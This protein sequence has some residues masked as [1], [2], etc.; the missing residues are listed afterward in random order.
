MCLLLA[1]IALYLVLLDFSLAFQLCNLD[2]INTVC[3]TNACL[4]YSHIYPYLLIHMSIFFVY[5]SSFLFTSGNYFL[6]DKRTPLG[7]SFNENFLVACSSFF[8]L[9]LCLKHFFSIQFVTDSFSGCRILRWPL[10]S[11]SSLMTLVH[12][13]LAFVVCRAEK[14]AFI[15]TAVPLQ[16]NSHVFQPIL[17]IFFLSLVFF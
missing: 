9:S 2:I 12:W 13:V 5:Y 7:V 4:F 8:L 1:P 10:Y 15:Q 3:I 16:V 11:V 17:S 6:S 14:S